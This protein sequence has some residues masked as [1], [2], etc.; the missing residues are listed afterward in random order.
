EEAFLKLND[1]QKINELV[2]VA[3]TFKQK[4]IELEQCVNEKKDK[5]FKSENI[6]KQLVTIIT[7]NYKRIKDFFRESIR[8]N[9]KIGDELPKEIE[10]LITIIEKIE[11]EKIATE[12]LYHKQRNLYND[13]EKRIEKLEEQIKEI[14][15]K[16]N[17]ARD[18]I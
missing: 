12:N 18:Y 2:K 3:N 5:K 7:N 6:E 1:K 14:E 17:G 10:R 15:K 4:T 13:S 16:Y 9:I 11:K 8:E